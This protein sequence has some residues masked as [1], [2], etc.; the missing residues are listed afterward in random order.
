MKGLH[1]IKITK[2]TIYLYIYSSFYPNISFK[3]NYP[4]SVL[5]VPIRYKFINKLLF[6]LPSPTINTIFMFRISVVQLVFVF[7]LYYFCLH[8]LF[9]FFHFIICLCSFDHVHHRH[10]H[11][12]ISFIFYIIKYIESIKDIIIL[13]CIH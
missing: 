6:Y 4:M 12:Y 11:T 1:Q 9:I 3:D 7:Y 13:I 10:N 5:S 8:V 2:I